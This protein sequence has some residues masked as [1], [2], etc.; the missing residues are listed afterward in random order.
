MIVQHPNTR[1]QKSRLIIITPPP[2]NEYQ[3]ESFDASKN[4]PHPSRTANHTKLYA[5][6]ARQVGASLNV[7]VVDLWTAFMQTTGW[8]DGQPLVGSREVPNNERL[9]RL[10]TDGMSENYV[11]MAFLL[12]PSDSLM[13][14]SI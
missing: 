14:G 13:Q 5:E 6:T 8:H 10:F 4:A 11:L 7:P 12:T 3:L 1:A 2:V 9:A